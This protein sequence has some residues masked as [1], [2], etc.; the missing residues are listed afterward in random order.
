MNPNPSALVFF[1]VLAPDD[2]AG[3]R[4]L[5]LAVTLD[6]PYGSVAA[7]SRHRPS[8]LSTAA[9]LAAPLNGPPSY[10]PP[11]PPLL[12]VP[13]GRTGLIALLSLKDAHR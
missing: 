5:L 1:T 4:F 8:P 13:S 6:P 12:P 11:P 2:R 3:P 7:G 9:A 10:P